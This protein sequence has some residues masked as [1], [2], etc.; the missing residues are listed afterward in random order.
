[1]KIKAA[2]VQEFCAG[3]GVTYDALPDK[4]MWGGITIKQY[5]EK[6]FN[7]DPYYDPTWL[8][9]IKKEETRAIRFLNRR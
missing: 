3:Y 6:E 8:K 2:T 9:P 5:W 7:K 4:E 1:M